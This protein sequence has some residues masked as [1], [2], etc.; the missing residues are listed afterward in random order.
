[1]SPYAA[2]PTDGVDIAGI[3]VAV[4]LSLSSAAAAA[5][6]CALRTLRVLL[7]LA[8]AGAAVGARSG[9]AAS[10]SDDAMSAHLSARA[11]PLS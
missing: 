10:S 5:L 6:C 11:A 3:A 7:R 2:I 4:S 1:M 9:T 8:R